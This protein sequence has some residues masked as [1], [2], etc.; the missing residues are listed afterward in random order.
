MSTTWVHVQRWVSLHRWRLG[1]PSVGVMVSKQ[2]VKEA[3]SQRTA[4]IYLV[5]I[6]SPQNVQVIDS[7]PADQSQ[8]KKQKE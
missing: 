5:P 2:V 1:S 3:L 8:G 6:T 7:A 4:V